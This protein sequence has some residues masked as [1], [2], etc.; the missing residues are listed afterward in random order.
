MSE[1]HES[2][3]GIGGEDVTDGRYIW[4]VGGY[5]GP[6]VREHVVGR[7]Y[8]GEQVSVKT[9]YRRLLDSDGPIFGPLTDLHRYC[10]RN[11]HC[12]DDD[13]EDVAELQGL[14]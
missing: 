14:D 12:F 7:L 10:W 11:E 4:P 9:A 8:V 2:V 13:R 1:S 6:S 5:G 3:D